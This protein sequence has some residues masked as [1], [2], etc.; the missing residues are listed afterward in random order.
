MNLAAVTIDYLAN[1]QRFLPALT[2]CMYE[3]W[4]P[5]F[6]ATRKSREE[7][8]QSM[9]D[10]CR[11]DSLPLALVAFQA[12]Q[13]LGTVALKP[14]D[15]DIRP[16]LTPWLG[17]LFVLEAYR[18]QGIGSLLITKVIG[19]AE[20]FGLPRLYLWT[21]SAEKLYLRHGWTLMERL[22]YHHYEISIMDRLMPSR[23]SKANRAVTASTS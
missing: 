5:L 18:H 15:L 22:P 10:R 4:R 6:Q 3:Y 1:Q 21:P 16:H 2:E 12:D 20:R 17:G 23:A 11:T 14:Q 9:V 7:F 19:K 8:A 13:V